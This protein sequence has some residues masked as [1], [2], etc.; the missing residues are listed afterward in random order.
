MAEMTTPQVPPPPPRSA[1]KTTEMLVS[2]NPQCIMVII[3]LRSGFSSSFAVTNVP[4][5][6]TTLN[7]A[8]KS[9]YKKC[10]HTHLTHSP[11]A[12]S[13][14]SPNF[15]L[16]AECPPPCTYPPARVTLADEPPTYILLWFF[17][18]RYNV[19]NGTP[20]PTVTADPKSLTP[21]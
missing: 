3:I 2:Q 1:Q 21:P 6:R 5:A 19:F 18:S 11:N 10:V 20:P 14:P 4:F 17:V 15:G 8:F 7:S 12:L 16:K 13:A 9:Q